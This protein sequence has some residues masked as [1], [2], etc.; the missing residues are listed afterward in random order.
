MTALVF[1]FSMFSEFVPRQAV[2]SSVGNRQRSAECGFCDSIELS[3]LR[4]SEFTKF[5][6]PFSVFRF[7]FSVFRF[8]FSECK[9]YKNKIEVA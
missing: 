9:K 4:K 3:N 6:F 2:N 1:V 7:P 5:R 8:P